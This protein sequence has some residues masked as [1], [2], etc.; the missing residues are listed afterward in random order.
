MQYTDTPPS[1]TSLKYSKIFL[2]FGLLTSLSVMYG[3]YIYGFSPQQQM[4]GPSWQRNFLKVISI[5]FIFFACINYFSVVALFRNSV[6]KFPLLYICVATFL[7]IPF[8]GSM[9]LQAVNLLFFIPLLAL[10]WE[11]DKGHELFRNIWKW[12][13]YIMLIQ[14][15][16]DPILK[17]YTGVGYVNLAL[18][19]GVGNANSFGYILLSLAIFVRTIWG[20][21]RLFYIFCIASY[22]TG[23]LA[24]LM[25]ATFIMAIDLIVRINKKRTYREIGL[26][27]LLVSIISPIL[28]IYFDQINLQSL[29]MSVQH[30][31]EK[32]NALLLILSGG[33]GGAASIDLR[34]EYTLNGLELVANSPFSLIWGHPEGIPMYTGDG[35]W[36]G[37][38]VTHGLVVTLA[39]LLINSTLIIK[40]I[41]LGSQEGKCAA[42]VVLLTCVILLSNRILDYW[43]S[44]F[45]YVLSVGYICNS[46]KLNKKELS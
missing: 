13:T 7:L 24:I 11:K 45:F 40:G 43:P 3:V 4:Q 31:R 25:I 1:L 8:L 29:S 33:E 17:I 28:I 26:G 22:F 35:W 39:F 20:S 21:S 38:L 30:S 19:G 27:L 23:S 9:E 42:Y 34:R 2:F 10:D 14:I 15:F 41:R 6:L 44:A 16:L 32:L 12:I 36:L 46:I 37:L 5:F 18:I